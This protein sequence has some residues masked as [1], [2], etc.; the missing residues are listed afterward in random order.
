MPKKKTN[1]EFLQEL[2]DK[3]I[4]YIPLDEYVN[5]R[6][7]I[8]WKCQQGH[9][10]KSSPE[11]ILSGNGCPYCSGRYPII[12]ETDLWT[13]HPDIAKMLKNHNDGFLVSYGSKKILDWT[14]PQCKNTISKSVTEVTHHGLVCKICS[15]GISY[16]EKFIINMLTQL[17]IDF[18]REK[19]FDWSDKKIY[20]F[21]LPY[22]NMIIETHGKQHYMENKFSN[23]KPRRS[24]NEEQY[25]DRYKE[26]LA[27][28]NRIEHYIQLDCRESDCEYIKNSIYNSIL[29]KFFNL[30]KVNWDECDI[31]ASNTL[32]IQVAKL[33]NEGLDTNAVSKELNVGKTFVLKHLKKMTKMGLCDYN[34]KKVHIQSNIY[35]LGKS[36]ICIETKKI[37]PSVGSVT[38]DGFI[39]QRVS[40]CCH[41]RAKTHRKL[42]WKFYEDYKG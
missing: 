33:W 31:Y 12:G 37:Y 32:S 5:G 21:Y 16:P 22:Y 14:C 24:L 28:L 2:K 10:F 34:P 3:N 42:H 41:D 13:T 40:L 15:D 1:D 4:S 19:T 20:D 38:E 9:I 26:Q 35:N 29:P 11:D 23:S 25:N 8:K 18:K 30:H 39:P 27:S 7:K 36:V 17:E 6:T